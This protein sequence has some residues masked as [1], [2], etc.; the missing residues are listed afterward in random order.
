MKHLLTLNKYFVKHKWRIG[1]G[2]FFV[3]CANLLNVINPLI[4]KGAVDLITKNISLVTTDPQHA[5]QVEEKIASDVLWMFLKYLFVALMAGGFTFLMRQT[6]IVV[7][8]LIEFDIKNE[9]YEHYQKLDLAFYR[10]NNTGD[11]MNRITEDVSRVRMYVGPAI[12][13][14]TN[15][16]FTITFAI[17]SMFWLNPTLTFWVLIPLPILSF[18]IYFVNELV[19]RASKNSGTTF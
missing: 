2:I 8:R 12:M 1:A 13:Y 3:I 17:I 18:I 15:L 16:F 11:L 19:G 10:K 7:S 6:I 9:I 14:T 5:A 4:T